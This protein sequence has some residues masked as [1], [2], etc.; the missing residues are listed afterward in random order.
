MILRIIT[1]LVLLVASTAQAVD[2]VKPEDLWAPGET[3]AFGDCPS[4][5][6]NKFNWGPTCGGGSTGGVE[7]HT[8]PCVNK[9]C[10]NPR[11]CADDGTHMSIGVGPNGD[12]ICRS[13]GP[14]PTMTGVTSTPTR[15]A[16]PTATITSTPTATATVTPTPT[17]TTTKTPTPTLTPTPTETVTVTPT[18]TATHTPETCGPGYA[19]QAINSFFGIATCIPVPPTPTLSATPGTPTATVTSGPTPTV[20]GTANTCG[21]VG[22]VNDYVNGLN[23]NG[24]VQCTGY[25]AALAGCPTN[26]PTVTKTPTPTATKT[27]TPTVT[28]TP[29]TTPTPTSIISPTASITATPTGA[30]TP[31]TVIPVVSNQVVLPPNIGLIFPRYWYGGAS[32]IDET[33]LTEANAQTVVSLRGRS[34]LATSFWC[35]SPTGPG[36]GVTSSLTLSINGSPVLFVSLYNN[37]TARVSNATTPIADGDL[38]DFAA[39]SS[40]ANGLAWRVTCGFSILLAVP[41]PTPTPTV[42]PTPT[43]TATPTL[44]ATPTVTPTPTKTATPTPTLSATPTA[45]V[46]AVPFPT[47]TPVHA[48]VSMAANGL[49][50]ESSYHFIL[51]HTNGLMCLVNGTATTCTPTFLIDTFSDSTAEGRWRLTAVRSVAGQGPAIIRRKARGTLGAETGVISGDGLGQDFWQGYNNSDATYYSVVT[52]GSFATETYDLGAGSGLGARYKIATTATGGI[53]AIDTLSAL[54][55]KVGIGPSALTPA[56]RLDVIEETLGAAVQKLQSVAT[57][58]DVTQNV[59]QSRVSTAGVTGTTLHNFTTASNVSY[60]VTVNVLARCTSGTACT[61]SQSLGCTMTATFKNNGGTLAQIGSTSITAAA[62]DL[63]GATCTVQ[64]TVAN[65]ACSPV[66]L[67]VNTAGN[68]TANGDLCIRL[69]PPSANL[70]ITWHD[71]MTIM[72]LGS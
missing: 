62:C 29:T 40:G 12:A 3:P 7:C 13:I 39:L 23:A 24:S 33:T 50:A 22:G 65:A 35:K 26:S 1:L 63:T 41:T 19:I 43:A 69:T 32:T 57:N 55:G 46:T 8:H 6:G 61:A 54:G 28:P 47:G 49:P 31:I 27:A 45:T 38:V 20:T 70:T 5:D 64:S 2:N 53:N 34:G 52:V 36:T 15:T 68:C 17:P 4:F 25:C 72:N 44:S 42:S 37:D 48:I 71:T 51:D 67:N 11:V 21:T 14:I 18:P 60:L 58:D 9:L 56:A 10:F 30:P 66:A 16:T 59:Y